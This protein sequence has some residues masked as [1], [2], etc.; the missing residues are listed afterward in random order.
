[1]KT[2]FTK[3][4]HGLLTQSI[5]EAEQR[6]AGEILVEVVANSGTYRDIDFLIGLAAAFALLTFSIFTSWSVSPFAL[7]IDLALVFV[8]FS[9][10]C[11]R[12]GM[13]RV[14]TS[15]KR[16]RKQVEA[17]AAFAFHQ[18]GATATRGRTGMLL[19]CSILERELFLIRDIGVERAVPLAAWQSMETRF[20]AHR[21]TFDPAV[22]LPEAIRELGELLALYLPASADNPDELP[23]APRFM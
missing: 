2:R 23:N 20:E 12:T 14:F 8:L 5:A 6:T 15:R 7:L 19:Y 11:R 16:R 10:F 9:E 22:F 18:L 13:R 21:K 3:A 17:A 1:M 4:H